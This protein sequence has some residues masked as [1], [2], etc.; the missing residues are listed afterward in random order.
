MVIA[1]PASED[2]R[3]AVSSVSKMSLPGV[4]ELSSSS[5]SGTDVS[6]CAVIG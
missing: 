4:I 3:N 2:C 5:E 6:D 1:S